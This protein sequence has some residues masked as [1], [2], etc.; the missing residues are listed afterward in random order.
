[1]YDDEPDEELIEE[2]RHERSSFKSTLNKKKLTKW[3]LDEAMIGEI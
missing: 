2:I 1:M 3:E